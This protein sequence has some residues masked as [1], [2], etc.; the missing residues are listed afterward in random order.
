MKRAAALGLLLT[1]CHP[2]APR[3]ADTPGD[4]LEA[5]ARR[6]GLIADASASPVGLYA[7]ENDRLCVTPTATG[8]RVGALVRFDDG[9]GCVARGSATRDGDRLRVSFGA[10]RFDARFDGDRVVFPAALPPSCNAS[11]TGRA[12]LTALAVDRLSQSVAE[13][14]AL[15]DPHGAP[16]C[17]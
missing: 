1:A 16:L 12:T 10:C 3:A 14:A 9:Q 11:C 6:A 2:A 15:T 13:A 17:I 7:R 8:L 4:R 5:A